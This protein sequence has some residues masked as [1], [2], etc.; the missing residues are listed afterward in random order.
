[1]RAHGPP[2]GE[3][4]A[5][6]IT[7]PIDPAVVW[8][9]RAAA[10]NGT[11]PQGTANIQVSYADL[12]DRDPRPLTISYVIPGDVIERRQPVVKWTALDDLLTL[13]T[14]LKASVPWTEAQ[15][16][17][18]AL[19]G[20]IP[21]IT[22]LRI[23]AKVHIR[24][25]TQP[26][27]RLEVD[28]RVTQRELA[29]AYQT[30]RAQFVSETRHRDLSDKHLELAVW[31]LET[32]GREGTWSERMKRWNAAHPAWAY[33]HARNFSSEVKLAQHRLLPDLM[34]SQV[35]SVYGYGDRTGDAGGFN[36]EE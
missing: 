15:A 2:A 35:A 22:P 26:R 25:A 18:Y 13:V 12:L 28:P 21:L 6:Y 32:E 23:D 11:L 16:T 19:T 1:M 30:A 5:S 3:E 17:V 9:A 27:L 8:Q 4:P 34:M 36:G 24:L 29:T 33:R 7:I 10:A 31:S 20:L 14:F